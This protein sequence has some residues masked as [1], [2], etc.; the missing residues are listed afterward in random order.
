MFLSG[1]ASPVL[2][3]SYTFLPISHLINSAF[4]HVAA[5][6]SNVMLSLHIFLS[7]VSILCL[8]PH[9]QSSTTDLTYSSATTIGGST[10][11]LRSGISYVSYESTFTVSASPSN[12]SPGGPAAST[13]SAAA[14][15]PAGQ[16][17]NGFPEL[18]SRSYSNITYIG[19][20]NSPFAFAQNPASNQDNGVV[21]QL[22]DGIRM[23]QGQTRFVNGTVYYCHTS[24]G[25][26][27]AGTAESYFANITTWLAA[28]PYEVITLLIGNGDYV[29]VQN[30]TAPLESSGLAKYAFFPPIIPMGL[31]NWPTLGELILNNQR[32][33][34]FM[35]YKANQTAVPYILDEFSQLW[36]TPFDPTDESFP[37]TVQRPPGL[38][39]QQARGR[40]YMENHNLNSELTVFGNTILVPATKKLLQTNA[41]SG[42]GSLGLAANNCAGEFVESRT[43]SQD[44]T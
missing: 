3:L 1:E 39:D 31:S 5:T 33:I 36:E 25:L 42:S 16:S 40:M 34:I 38:N 26:L 32:A 44:G 18:C 37:C 2:P 6:V 7:L 35:D 4:P 10:P 21:A 13:T 27:N 17:C 29:P 12:I 14:S 23:L 15:I 30:F 41:V 22:N 8:N 28:N 43:A 9:A 20:H 19:A 11:P 24:C